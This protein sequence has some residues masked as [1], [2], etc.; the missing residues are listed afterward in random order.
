MFRSS[1]ENRIGLSNYPQLLSTKAQGQVRDSYSSNKYGSFI[2][3][4]K[5]IIIDTRLKKLNMSISRMYKSPQASN[6]YF[7][8]GLAKGWRQEV[9]QPKGQYTQDVKEWRD[10]LMKVGPVGSINRERALIDLDHVMSSIRASHSRPASGAFTERSQKVKN[11]RSGLGS[12]FRGLTHSQLTT[13]KFDILRAQSK[14]SQKNLFGWHGSGFNGSSLALKL[15][16]GEKKEGLRFESTDKQRPARLKETS[17]ES[18]FSSK[19]KN[20]R[21]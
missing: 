7:G 18:M 14:L 8:E 21:G 11:D 16:F 10:A 3:S 2:D 1:S 6:N 17:R 20:L 15:N 13:A 9:R 19:A 12:Q 5:D 4:G